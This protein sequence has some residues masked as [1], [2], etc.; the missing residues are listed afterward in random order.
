[1]S[2]ESDSR[3]NSNTF[4]NPQWETKVIC[5]RGLSRDKIGVRKTRALEKGI[6]DRIQMKNL[7][8]APS[9]TDALRYEGLTD[10]VMIKKSTL[11]I[12]KKRCPIP[13]K[14]F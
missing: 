3:E 14:R 9:A 2:S 4:S 6:T 11:V 7:I 10:Q 8:P 1:M 5:L 13:R 12:Y